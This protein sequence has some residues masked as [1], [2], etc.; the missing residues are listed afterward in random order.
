MH[1]KDNRLNIIH[2]SD[3]HICK[4]T[5]SELREYKNALVK[6]KKAIFHLRN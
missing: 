4:Q 6:D 1:T 2:I 3:T 5:I